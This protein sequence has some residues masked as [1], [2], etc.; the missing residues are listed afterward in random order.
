MTRAITSPCCTTLNLPLGTDRQNHHHYFQTRRNFFFRLRPAITYEEQPYWCYNNM[1]KAVSCRALKIN[2]AELNR[3]QKCN[4]MNKFYTN[5]PKT[6]FETE[7]RDCNNE[8]RNINISN[9]N[10]ES[11]HPPSI[12]MKRRHSISTKKKSYHKGKMVKFSHR[13]LVKKIQ[14]HRDLSLK[15]KYLIWN[16]KRELITNAKRNKIEFR[17][18]GKDWRRAMEEVE[19]WRDMKSGELIHPIHV[20][21]HVLEYYRKQYFHYR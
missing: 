3:Y 16:S 2:P 12:L 7:S 8:N 1:H 18:E 9:S 14:S 11:N 6:K 17:A 19:M 10:R 4:T 20:P 13:V 21:N 15:T 5:F